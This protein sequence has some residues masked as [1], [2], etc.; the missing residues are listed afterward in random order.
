[1]GPPAPASSLEDD[2]ASIDSCISSDVTSENEF[3]PTKITSDLS[4]NV[5]SI[6]I[7]PFITK[8]KLLSIELQDHLH[9]VMENET[10]K[11][12]FLQ[13]LWNFFCVDPNINLRLYHG[14][15]YDPFGESR[16][17]I[18]I[19]GKKLDQLAGMR[20]VAV[21]GGL[22]WRKYLGI[23]L[24]LI[25]AAVVIYDFNGKNQPKITN[26]LPPGRD[27]NYVFYTDYTLTDENHCTLLASYCRTI[28]ENQ[29][30]LEFLQTTNHFPDIILLDGS[31]CCPPN[32]YYIDNEDIQAFYRICLKTYS[33][34]YSF[35]EK[36]HILLVGSVKDSRGVIL[37]E[38]FSRAFPFF[39][40]KYPTLK[41]FYSVQYRQIFRRF[42]DTELLFKLL[43]SNVRTVAFQ[44]SSDSPN[45]KIKNLTEKNIN[46]P[47][48]EESSLSN[49]YARKNEKVKNQL[50]SAMK[51]SYP[52]Y[53][54]YLQLSQV[55]VPL[56][57]EFISPSD[58]EEIP[59]RI[60]FIASILVPLS[61]INPSCTLPLPQIEAHMRA[62]LPPQELDM[63]SAQLERLY[64]KENL[65]DW[66]NP[67]PMVK[68][69]KSMYPA[70]DLP[71][72]IKSF[73]STFMEKRHTRLPF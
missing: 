18:P 4:L 54:S 27:S 19:S 6:S 2:N 73:Y 16:F 28:A 10:E 55:D 7:P 56:R 67:V 69:G 52:I 24:T 30:L 13:M 33:D 37:R 32:P 61:N 58:V 63:I 36:H 59:R 23:Q 12:I 39:M 45:Y 50:S 8:E 72:K 62:H 1:M 22:G 42:S 46:M 60:E 29:L 5:E 48:R 71:L 11:Q 70:A 3:N 44:Y 57:I 40:K 15:N 38:L 17:F 25:K 14:P 31:L 26:F 34:L 68:S 20:I 41:P 43:P 49:N 66:A 51:F 53:A 47:A 21:D 64:Q 35:C 9:R 65:M